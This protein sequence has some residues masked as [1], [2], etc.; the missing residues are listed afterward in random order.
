[1]GGFPPALKKNGAPFESR[2]RPEAY[3]GGFK[4]GL[5][6][7]L[8]D[9]GKTEGGAKGEHGTPT[10]SENPAGMGPA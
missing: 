1:L 2:S 6:G 9:L 7:A 8:D 4:V 5:Y 3:R 10:K